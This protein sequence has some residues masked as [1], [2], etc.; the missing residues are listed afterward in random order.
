MRIVAPDL[1]QATTLRA[2]PPPGLA[3]TPLAL[4]PSA[5]LA[6]LGAHAVLWPTPWLA[7]FSQSERDAIAELAA[8]WPEPRAVVLTDR[9]SLD[10]AADDPELEARA[11][12][13]RLAKLMPAGWL[14]LDEDQVGP[15]LAELIADAPSLTARR[16]HQAGERLVQELRDALEQRADSLQEQIVAARAQAEAEHADALE[17]HARERR[18]RHHL[19]AALRHQA[20]T[21]IVDLRDRVAAIA[22]ELP[23]QAA[24]VPPTVDLTPILPAWLEQVLHHELSEALATWRTALAADLQAL[25]DDSDAPELHA[26][27]LHL[28]PSRSPGDWGQRLALG[29][30]LGG[31]VALLAIG[32]WLPGLAALSSGLVAHP[33]LAK[34]RSEPRRARLIDRA[35]V[36]LLELSSEVEHDLRQQLD[37]ALAALEADEAAPRLDE[38]GL[39][40]LRQRLDQLNAQLAALEPPLGAPA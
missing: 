40:E 20:E 32:L 39:T 29:A 16:V 34:L 38:R 24:A 23:A 13:A 26:P 18:A 21:L 35:R 9:A 28:G 10:L 17:Q 3:S 1:R 15:W 11:V 4:G 6:L 31:G 25:D 8:W 22:Q 36:A 2:A 30:A 7:A 14:L 33:L 5:E 12:R 19:T 27:E 37:T